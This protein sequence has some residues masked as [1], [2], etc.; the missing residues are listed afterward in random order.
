MGTIAADA[1][2]EII[3]YVHSSGG[4][5]RTWYDGV[6]YTEVPEPAMLALL[7]LGGMLSLVRRRK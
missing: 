2:G 7:G 3:V 5:Q 6:A 1:N 4:V